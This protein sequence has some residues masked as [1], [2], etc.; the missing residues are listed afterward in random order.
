MA[1]NWFDINN[2]LI[3][4]I[5]R[6]FIQMLNYIQYFMVTPPVSIFLYV[7]LMLYNLGYKIE[8]I[9]FILLLEIFAP[10]SYNLTYSVYVQ[11]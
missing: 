5:L 4:C 11:S 1:N 9:T 3:E 6:L 2:I 10:G 8:F 7:I